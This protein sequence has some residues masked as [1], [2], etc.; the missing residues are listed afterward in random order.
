MKYR[1]PFL[2]VLLIFPMLL[3]AQGDYKVN[4]SKLYVRV[5][6]SS[7]AK[8]VGTLRKGDV[9]NV[10]SITKGWAKITYKQKNR[11]VK[12]QSLAIIKT[13]NDTPQESKKSQDSKKPQES[14]QTNESQQPQKTSIKES[15]DQNN[16][17]ESSYEITPEHQN[18][19]VIED[20]NINSEDEDKLS[21]FVSGFGGMTSYLWSGK[22]PKYGI[23]YG[24]G[25][26]VRLKYNIFSNKI[27]SG[28]F[29]D[30]T[31]EYAHRGSK[32]YPIN[33][34]SAHLQP[35]G[36]IYYFNNSMGVFAK[37]GGYFAY[38]ISQKIV[39]YDVGVDYGLSGAIG[40]R[41]KRYELSVSYD[42]GLANIS[43]D[44]P[45]ELKN[46]GALLTFSYHF[47]LK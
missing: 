18:E 19:L 16:S 31:A 27:P 47:K 3:M 32:T 11:Y 33:Y 41:Y 15:F 10:I 8:V 9:V 42:Y 29:G 45:V 43:K 17:N 2:L 34:V 20:K 37:A 6:P 30:L 46:V 24:G 25:V 40:F 21:I 28:L 39:S 5:S 7:K 4:V 14:Q 36:Y 26:G 12:A 1:L 44:S 23:A 13:P 22:T 38:P 35:I